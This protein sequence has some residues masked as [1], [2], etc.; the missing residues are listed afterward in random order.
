MSKKRILFVILQ[1]ILEE[2]KRIKRFN[3]CINS[4]EEFSDNELVMYATIKALE[5]IGEA[6]KKIPEDV[7]QKYPIDW[8]KIAGLRDILIHEY[9]GIDSKIIWNIIEE[10]T[11]RI[12]KS[13]QFFN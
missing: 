11:S 3:K 4:V 2:I 12:R 5:N 10:K 6:V 8:K 9:F 1:D 7:R 13:C